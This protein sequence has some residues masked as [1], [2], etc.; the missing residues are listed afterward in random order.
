M[1]KL[2]LNTLAVALGLSFSGVTHAAANSEVTQ[3]R[4]EVSQLRAM[5]EQLQTEQKKQAIVYDV[6]ATKVVAPVVKVDTTARKG[7]GFTAGGAEFNIYG[8]VRADAGYQFEGATGGTP[9]NQIATA[10]LS[11]DNGKD[12]LRSTLSATRLGLDFKTATQKGDV[13]GKIEVDFLGSN[14]SLRIRH[15]YMTYD[16]WL[17][18][19]TWSNFAVPDYMAETI[20]AMGY[21]GQ[22]VKRTPQVRYTNKFNPNTSLIMALEDPKDAQADMKMRLP[23]LT[24]RVT[25]KFADNFSIGARA[26]LHDKKT[27]EDNEMAWGVGLGAKYDIT[28]STTLKADY[29]HVDGDSS[30]IYNSNQGFVT[31]ANK[32]IKETNAFDSINVG[33]TQKFNQQWRGTLGFGYMKAD[34]NKDYLGYFTDKTKVNKD[35]WQGWGNVFY[36]PV[37]PLS[38][39]LE[40]VYGERQTFSTATMDSKTGKDSRLNAVAMY[41]F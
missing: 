7:L 31:D 24:A 3:L 40:Y 41:N 16:D 2:K 34:N 1:N 8:N 36:S 15:A 19:Q 14:D 25:H 4:N 37:Q 9:Y 17:I 38:F 35:I 23:A 32:N 33:V 12:R 26:M 20:D 5:I 28:P 6:Q 39:G 10:E 22:S 29:Y 30:F 11:G 18:G 13:A 21:V 27:N